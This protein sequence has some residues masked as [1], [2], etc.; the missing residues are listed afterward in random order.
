MTAHTPRRP[1]GNSRS[2]DELFSLLLPFLYVF[3]P[4]QK[5]SP[6]QV[7]PS[8]SRISHKTSRPTYTHRLSITHFRFERVV[9]DEEATEEKGI[10]GFQ[11]REES[12]AKLTH[13]VPDRD[14]DT[15]LAEQKVMLRMGRFYVGCQ[16]WSSSSWKYTGV[17][18]VENSSFFIP[19]SLCT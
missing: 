10:K 19:R 17:N 6:T 1:K 2:A 12:C 8:E 18:I 15:W 16:T 4:P 13:L 11:D 14:L 3:P 5:S 7:V 9:P